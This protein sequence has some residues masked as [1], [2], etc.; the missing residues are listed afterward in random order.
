M[1]EPTCVILT[2]DNDTL[3]KENNFKSLIRKIHYGIQCEAID[4]FRYDTSNTKQKLN[5]NEYHCNKII[6]DSYISQSCISSNLCNFG[7]CLCHD[8]RFSKS[9]CRI[10]K[11]CYS[12]IRL[13]KLCD[14][15][16]DWFE[17]SGKLSRCI[18]L[19]YDKWTAEETKIMLHRDYLLTK[20][21]IDSEVV[22]KLPFFFDITKINNYNGGEAVIVEYRQRKAGLKW[23][24]QTSKVFKEYPINTRAIVPTSNSILTSIRKMEQTHRP[25]RERKRKTK[26]DHLAA[27][28]LPGT[29]ESSEEESSAGA[30][31][32]TDNMMDVDTESDHEN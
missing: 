23:L 19:N 31:P 15:F 11:P 21:L 18:G 5:T 2:L 28:T 3:I 25:R 24:K 12:W 6:I 13:L 20:E 7:S 16:R 9:D 32:T 10:C 30:M 26:Y 4:A 14:G 27:G 22:P 17:M 8:C 1:H 29:P